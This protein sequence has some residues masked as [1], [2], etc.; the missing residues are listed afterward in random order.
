MKKISNRKILQT[1]EKHGGNPDHQVCRK[2][3]REKSKERIKKRP[4][5]NGVGYSDDLGC[6]E[7]FRKRP[8]L[9]EVFAVIS[10]LPQV[11]LPVGGKVMIP[12]EQRERGQGDDQKV[13]QKFFAFS[14]KRRR[15]HPYSP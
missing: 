11:V 14:P 2:K 10:D 1:K 3:R 12:S 15:E 6:I 13:G 5:K 8:M 4:V 9:S 7:N